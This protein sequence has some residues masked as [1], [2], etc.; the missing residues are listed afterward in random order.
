MFSFSCFITVLMTNWTAWSQSCRFLD[1]FLISLF[2]TQFDWAF[3][4]LLLLLLLFIIV[5]V[6]LF[7][8][9]ERPKPQENRHHASHCTPLGWLT[10][11]PALKVQTLCAAPSHKGKNGCLQLCVVLFQSVWLSPALCSFPTSVVVSS[12]VLSSF[13]QRGCLL[14]WVVLFLSAW[15]STALCCPLPVS[16]RVGSGEERKGLGVYLLQPDC[17]KVNCF[18]LFALSQSV[19]RAQS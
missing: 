1:F 13:S 16:M 4:L 2:W 7:V 15:L 12:F 11:A 18:V 19:Q 8:D 10:A 6:T 9:K 17:V 14:L 5:C 3:A